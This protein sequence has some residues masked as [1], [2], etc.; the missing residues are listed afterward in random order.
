MALR[1]LSHSARPAAAR[2]PP[3]WVAPGVRLCDSSRHLPRRTDQPAPI[4]WRPAEL[5]AHPQSGLIRR[6]PSDVRAC[7]ITASL[8]D[9]RVCR[10]SG[11][12]RWSS[13]QSRHFSSSSSGK[14]IR[15]QAPSE[16]SSSSEKA[17][18]TEASA[19]QAIRPE[20]SSEQSSEPPRSESSSQSSSEQAAEAQPEAEQSTQNTAFERLTRMYRRSARQREGSPEAI[21]GKLHAREKSETSYVEKLLSQSKET[22]EKLLPQFERLSRMSG[23]VELAYIGIA[24]GGL[25]FFTGVGVVAWNWGEVRTH[26]AKESAEVASEVIRDKQLQYDANLFAKEMLNQ[27][28]TDKDV[29]ANTSRW[30]MGIL[31][32]LKNEIGDLFVLILALEPVVQAVNKLADRLVEYLCNSSVIKERVGQLLVDAIC[33]D[34][35]RNAAGQWAVD[36]VSREDVVFGFRDLVVSALKTEAVV[37]EARNLAVQ[38]VNTVL[39]DPSTQN[40]AKRALNDTL[41]DH[42]V[43]QTAKDSLW[44]MVMPWGA[45]PKAVTG[46]QKSLKALEEVMTME[47][48]T[49]EERQM[50]R[51][52][53]VR[54]TQAPK[55]VTTS[56]TPQPPGPAAVP[57]VA[58]AVVETSSAPMPKSEVVSTEPGPKRSESSE[59]PGPQPTKPNERSVDALSAN[60]QTEE[61]TR[62]EASEPAIPEIGVSSET[63]TL[64]TELVAHLAEPTTPT[65]HAAQ[66]AGPTEDAFPPAQL[67][68]TTSS[69]APVQPMPSEADSPPSQHAAA[70][71]PQEHNEVVT[72]ESADAPPSQPVAAPQPQENHEVVTKVPQ[73]DDE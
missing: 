2:R 33:L 56:A 66:L 12:A 51:S 49:Q 40:V 34:V 68:S 46:D 70:P 3:W 27:L 41:S 47:S 8:G 61:I 42:E 1:S 73:S 59:V 19:D 57:A 48:L 25:V 43:R 10:G 23:K 71:Q 53:Q 26:A 72:K 58:A 54:L 20:A 55:P 6:I 31:T 15:P 60:E 24:V 32:T 21:L 29:A 18:K 7:A 64:P 22:N 30:I 5:S 62:D 17:P 11:L 9:P 52:L 65:E 69:N 45:S 28:L 37:D 38:I 67:Q 13:L 14:A 44:S 16:Q 39:N 63:T 4:E 50:L 36:L 35:S